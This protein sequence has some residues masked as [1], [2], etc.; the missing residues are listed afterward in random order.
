MASE[1]AISLPFSIDTS[2]SIGTTTEQSKIWTDR[3]RSVLG[4]SLRERVMRPTFGTLIPFSLFNNVDNAV[5]EIRDEVTRAFDRYLQL[6][7]LQD[8]TV[9]QDLYT[10]TLKVTVT[11]ALPNQEVN[12]TTVGYVTIQG[13]IPMYE[14]LL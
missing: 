8:T 9:E 3:V 2:G 1:K 7:T 13:T 11:Y 12:K 6:L 4:T 10:N 5:E 14:E